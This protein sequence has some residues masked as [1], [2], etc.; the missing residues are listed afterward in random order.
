MKF[1]VTQTFK[2]YLSKAIQRDVSLGQRPQ[3]YSSV[4][5]TNPVASTERY[6]VQLITCK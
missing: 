3:S 1:Q 4:L 2:R 5:R 6:S